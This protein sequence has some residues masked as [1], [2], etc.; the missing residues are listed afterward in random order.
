MPSRKNLSLYYESRY[1]LDYKG[2]QEP[3]LKHVYRAGR[4]A[5]QRLKTLRPYI[6]NGCPVLDIGSGGGEWIYVLQTMGF[7][8]IG[9]EADRGYSNFARREL[10]VPISSMSLW[11]ATFPAGHFG[12][13]TLFH[14]LEHLP[15]PVECLM[16][17][18]KWLKH[19]GTLIIEVPNIASIHQHPHKRFHTAHLFG[20]TPESLQF[21]A[22]KAGFAPIHIQ[23][24]RYERNILAVFGN[25]SRID[26]NVIATRPQPRQIHLK[27]VAGYYMMPQTYVRFFQRMCQFGYEMSAVWASKS[28]KEVLDSLVELDNHR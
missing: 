19:D 21:A 24:D 2:V 17:I 11:E 8:S 6:W 26:R 15:E 14:V 9:I 1:R 27:S 7:D 16:Q 25:D 4:L 18:T 22:K 28:A 3:K 23:L 13:V 20:F 5:V 12:A 10:G